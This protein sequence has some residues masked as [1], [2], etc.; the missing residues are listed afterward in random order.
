MIILIGSQKGGCGKSTLAVN[1]AGELAHQGKDVCLVDA[2]Q[3][4][5]ALKWTQYREEIDSVPNVHSVSASGNITKTLRDLGKRY[6]YIVCDVAGRDSS[7]LRSGMVASDIVICP[8]RPSQFDLDTIPHFTEVFL[9][10]KN[11]N[12]ELNGLIVL[13]LCPTLPTI[14]EADQAE[15][16]ISEINELSISPIRIHDRKAYRDAVSD[17]FCVKEWKDPK[18]AQEI[19]WLVKESLL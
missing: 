4:Q 8:M 3:Q 12:T 14:K 11:F 7:E 2:D 13:N 15:S 1:I 9:A 16:F 5:S 17:G 6:E 10:A 19:E 18:A